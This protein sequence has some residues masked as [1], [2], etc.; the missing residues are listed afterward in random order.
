MIVPIFLATVLAALPIPPSSSASIAPKIMPIGPP[1][2]VVSVVALS[3]K[4]C[5][6]AVFTVQESADCVHWTNVCRTNATQVCFSFT[7]CPAAFFAVSAAN[8]TDEFTLAWSSSLSMGVS[9]YKVFYGP[10]TNA[11]TNAICTGQTSAIFS[12]LWSVPYYFS[13]SAVGC[14]TSSPP[15]AVCMFVPSPL[16]TST[17]RVTD[18]SAKVYGR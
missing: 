6:P 8:Y 15:S 10:A 17:N 14:G 5:K 7:N 12:N 3:W 9:G 1:A 11:M 16:F 18:V 2:P 4:Y 13:V